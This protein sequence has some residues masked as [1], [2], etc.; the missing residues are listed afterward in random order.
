[1]S[2]ASWRPLGTWPDEHERTAC[3]G[4]CCFSRN[5][6]RSGSITCFKGCAVQSSDV[7]DFSHVFGPDS[8][9]LVIVEAIGTARTAMV[10]GEGLAVGLRP[11]ASSQP[12]AHEPQ[13]HSADPRNDETDRSILVP[14]PSPFGT[15]GRREGDAP[16]RS[17]PLWS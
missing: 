8:D 13:V 12:R 2:E 17:D 9:R 11:G 3:R 14:V 1:M 16:L 10:L 15:G 6:L 5:S 4:I 7:D